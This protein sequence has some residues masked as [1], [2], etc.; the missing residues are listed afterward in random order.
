[1]AYRGR[2]PVTSDFDVRSNDSS[3]DPLAMSF[4]ENKAKSAR[5]AT[6]RR[7]LGST[8]PSKQNR[9]GGVSEFEFSSPSKAMVMNTPRMGSASPWRIKVTVHAEP[10]S[11]DENAQSPSVKRVTTRTQTTTVPLKDPDASS[12]VK[13]GRGRPRKSDVGATPKL[14]RAGT[15]KKRAARSKSRDLST[16]ATDANAADV[17]TDAPPKRRRGRPRKNAQPPVEDEDI[18]MEALQIHD[19]PSPEATPIPTAKSKP[20][21]SQKS[22]RFATPLA[23]V[24]DIETT[25]ATPQPP[26][27]ALPQDKKQNDTRLTL[28][29]DRRRRG[30]L[31]EYE[32]P[33]ID[34]PPRTEL[35]DRLRARKNTPH[36]KKAVTISSDEE[37]DQDSDVL[38]PTSGEDDNGADEEMED[39]FATAGAPEETRAVVEHESNSVDAYP[40]IEGPVACGEMLSDQPTEDDEEELQDATNF[41]FDE[42]TTRMPDDTTVMDSENFSMISV[43]SLPHSGGL[44]SP[45]KAEVNSKPTPQSGSM[46]RHE[47]LEPSMS[48]TSPPKAQQV[49]APS[50]KL[51]NV[52]SSLQ[53]NTGLS[54]PAFRRFVTPVIDAAIPSAPPEPAPVQVAPPKAETPGLG[55]VVTAG[56]ALQG[57][58]DPSRL[59]PEPSQKMLDDKR[60]RLDD[61]FRGFSDSTRKELQ[62]GLR[63]GEQ[64]AQG[65][66]E[67]QSSRDHSSPI[68]PNAEPETAPKGVFKSKRKHREPRLLTPEDHDDFVVTEDVEA[69]GND[70]QYPILDTT[71]EKSLP[72]PARS[73][74]EMSWQLDSP[75]AANINSERRH[76]VAMEDQPE[77]SHGSAQIQSVAHAVTQV[78][79]ED[80]GDIWQEEA[81]R[82]SNSAGTD[83]VPQVQDLFE[84]GPVAPARG[85]LPRTLYSDEAESPQQHAP[86]QKELVEDEHEENEVDDDEDMSEEDDPVSDGSD[87]TGMFF[88]SNMPNIFSKRHSRDLKQRKTEKLDLTLLMNEASSIRRVRNEADG[89]LEAY[90]AQERSL[91]EIEEVTELSRTHISKVASSPPRMKMLSPVRK[92]VPLFQ[93]A[94]AKPIESL[95]RDNESES[96]TETASS[97]LSVQ[98]PSAVAA[99]P[100]AP[101]QRPTVL[102]RMTSSLWSTVTRQ[103]KVVKPHPILSKLSPLPKVEPWTKTHYKT[104]DRLYAINQKH[105]ALFSPN[106]TPPTPLSQTNAHL[107]QKF[108]NKNKQP[109]VGAVFAAWGYEFDMTEELVVLCQVF[110]ELMSLDSVKAYETLKGR[111]IEMGDCLPG[112]AGDLIDAEEV[113]RRLATVILG[114]EVRVDEKE[115]VKIDRTRGLEIRWPQQ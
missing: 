19:E 65:Q 29:A 62:A 43:E 53:P 67:G 61:L 101:Q 39:P 103:D 42:G 15:P 115:G 2:S 90:E 100:E 31:P 106:I 82:S 72:S 57:V 102:T 81:S 41:A 71:T 21:T 80:Y 30:F 8:S 87:D 32:L 56:V 6:P 85:K 3:P 97:S 91:N 47:Y 12:P 104:L 68:K 70:V 22:T 27:S 75:P 66:E 34:T 112:K 114:E 13:R 37:S 89:Y 83:N 63:L 60:D 26:S 16:G 105:L 50:P 49:S 45:P 14:K 1:M 54:R 11:D 76:S 78:H 36:A 10:G 46:L 96:T 4:D 94:P 73:E 23:S 93:P 111:E 33:V 110:C 24:P 48:V 25:D 109:Y 40:E 18:I 86:V 84:P 108:L 58:L 79:E 9:R 88:Q 35:G 55:R 95:R 51:L 99:Q 74:N 17:D 98:Q 44:T 59:T 69:E 28:P 7:P 20:S 92:R 64:L 77:Q 5:K 107:L 38:T 113:M 52:S